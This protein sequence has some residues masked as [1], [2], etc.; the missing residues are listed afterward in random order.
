M[1]RLCPRTAR[2]PCGGE[3]ACVPCVLTAVFLVRS[4][5][6]GRGVREGF[7]QNHAVEPTAKSIGEEK[8]GVSPLQR[9]SDKP[10]SG[11]QRF[12]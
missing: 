3:G 10:S 9:G 12:S 6:W 5:G 7:Q 11:G 2:G 8:G 4:L 1:H